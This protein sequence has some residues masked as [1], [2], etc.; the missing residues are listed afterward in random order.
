MS[1]SPG[2]KSGDSFNFYLQKSI[3]RWEP[4]FK[5]FWCFQG[6]EKEW[7]GTNGLKQILE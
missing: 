2:K 3:A 1:Q 4:N 6:V 7:L 5:V